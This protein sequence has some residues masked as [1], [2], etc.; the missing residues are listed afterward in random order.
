MELSL[1]NELRDGFKATYAWIDG[2][3]LWLNEI[4]EFYSARAALEREYSERLSALCSGHLAK[5]SA[6]SVALSVGK[7]P[8]QTPGSLEGASVVAWNEVLTQAELAAKDHAE[9]G[10]Q[11]EQRVAKK[12]ST[13]S[14]ELGN[15]LNRA[16]SLNNDAVS[17]MDA[18]QREMEQ[19]KRRYDESCAHLESARSKQSRGNNSVRLE[20]RKHEMH[21]SKNAYL[22]SIAQ[23]NR[24]KDKYFFQDVP[25]AVDVLQDLSDARVL[26]V[27]SIWKDAAK[28]EAR[29][30]ENCK[31]RTSAAVEVIDKNTPELNTAMFLKHNIRNWHEPKDFTFQPSP[32]WHDD[33]TFA[34]DGE[35]EAQ[36]LRVRLAQ[37]ERDRDALVDKTRDELAKLAKFHERRSELRA[38]NGDAKPQEVLENMLNYVATLAS[39]TSHETEKLRAEVRAE[40]IYNNAGSSIDL[41]TDGIDLSNQNKKS[42]L[43]S[44]LKTRILQDKLSINNPKQFK[45]NE[46][47]EQS[48]VKSSSN[49]VFRS[50]SSA[51]DKKVA[52][53]S[54]AN[55]QNISN[56]DDSGS[57]L[58]AYSSQ[59]SDEVSINLGDHIRKLA[60]DTGS[61]WTKI[62]NLTSGEVGLVPTSYIKLPE[63][64]RATGPPP[65]RKASQRIVKAEYDY[66]AQGEDELSIQAGDTIQVIK[67]DDGSGWTYGELNGMKG[68]FPTNYCQKI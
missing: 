17:R 64:K 34:L 32:V 4:A 33:D 23:A 38:L 13:L 37:A 43:F 7:H 46:S 66:E 29:A 67:A 11:F 35:P 62:Q 48:P 19:C 58:Y 6:A 3:I 18:T 55:A 40:C 47:S 26:H 39:F 16:R 41:S 57:V 24:V 53:N 31:L 15:A 14:R 63:S 21:I 65:P 68:L 20:S 52:Q 42:G 9:L 61:G 8:A 22:L 45:R 1:G 49:S 44:K 25:E 5:K 2:S 28:F 60:D 12:L 36:D 54:T 10:T 50:L 30:Y 51:T 59:D 27:N 56:H